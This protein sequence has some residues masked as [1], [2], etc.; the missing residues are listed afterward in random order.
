MHQAF[1]LT[2]V[3]ISSATASLG[4]TANA[5]PCDKLRCPLP[6]VRNIRSVPPVGRALERNLQTAVAL[7]GFDLMDSQT[8]KKITTLTNNQVIVVDKIPGMTTPSFNIKANV[9]GNG[10]KS[11][12]Y[13]YGTTTYYRTDNYAPFSFCGNRGSFYNTCTLLGLGTHVVAA[14]PYTDRNGAGTAGTPVTVTFTIVET[15]PVKAPTAAPKAPTA[16]AFNIQ[17]A[18]SSNV[19]TTH[20]AVITQAKEK[21]ESVITGDMPD[22][23]LAGL[24]INGNCNHPTAVDD[25]Y[26]CAEYIKI[27]EP[28]VVGYGSSQWLNPISGLPSNGHIQFDPDAATSMLANGR[29]LPV[30]MHEMG[31]VLGRFRA[32]PNGW[33]LVVCLSRAT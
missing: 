22:D 33:S 7:T 21:W 10:V 29:F 28:G 12:V 8:E 32:A 23:N 30:I 5:V 31:H 17:L 20:Q 26:I 24:Q 2:L 3:V 13:G 27:N 11:V 6:A 16:P 15:A 25:L 4:D 9:V 19:P 1:I 14:T 18:F